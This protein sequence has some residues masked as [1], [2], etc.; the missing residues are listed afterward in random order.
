[1]E[2]VM[3]GSARI[4][5]NGRAHGGKAGDQT[6]FEVSTQFWYAHEKGWRVFRPTSENQA[7]RIAENMELACANSCIGYDQY[8]RDTL[9][10]T[11]QPFGFDCGKVKTP[12]ETDCSALV[13]VCCAYAGI[14][15]KTFNTETEPAVLMA[16]GKFS[17]LT[18]SMFTKRSNF[19][20]R[21]D[22]LVTASKGHTVVVLT[23]GDQT[24]SLKK[25]DRGE[26]V[27]ELQRKLMALNYDL[28][29]WGADGDY[30]KKTAEAV[31]KFQQD[32]GLN[33]DG[34]YGEET[35]KALEEATASV[36]RKIRIEGGN[37]WVRT[38]PGTN[39]KKLGIA[40]E[41]EEYEWGFVTHDNGWQLI[42]YHN[43]NGWVSG[44][45][46]KLV[47]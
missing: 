40:K 44:R 29:K 12:C 3:I 15:L 22:I 27:A 20:R 33:D 2:K 17:E 46:G 6:N 8:E 13:R 25:G 34:V 37:C 11:S 10:K 42:D 14:F 30:G 4:D 36:K 19:L 32:R 23:D 39:G 21:G 28:G 38:A 16:S 43:Q 7:K 9:Y 1:M 31:R 26:E 41:G 24:Y 47:E 45:Y 5:E 35:R 18:G